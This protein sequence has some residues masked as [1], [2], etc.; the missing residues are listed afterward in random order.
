M[1]FFTG[2]YYKLVNLFKNVN[3][4][5]KKLFPANFELD[6]LYRYRISLNYFFLTTPL[7]YKQ[8]NK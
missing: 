4:L 7:H 8:Q 2:F 3:L 1:I 6:I 5:K